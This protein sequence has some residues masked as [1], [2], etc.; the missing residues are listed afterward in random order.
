MGRTARFVFAG[1]GGLAMARIKY[2]IDME[3]F[4]QQ[5]E[6]NND[7]GGMLVVMIGE[8][9][10]PLYGLFVKKAEDKFC[11]YLRSRKSQ[12][13][14]EYGLCETAEDV[15]TLITAEV[16]NLASTINDADK[17]YI[18]TNPE[19]SEYKVKPVS[20]TEGIKVCPVCGDEV[21]EVGV[22]DENVDISYDRLMEIA[23]IVIM[24]LVDL[25]GYTDDYFEYNLSIQSDELYKI[26][27]L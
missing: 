21:E 3:E 6:G 9:K 18:C 22:E 13:V 10:E 20:L 5:V 16:K 1:E 14:I 7:K 12:E 26:L 27:N 25:Y 11:V 4:K 19:C 8:D 17:E 2:V 24:E 15:E 23:N